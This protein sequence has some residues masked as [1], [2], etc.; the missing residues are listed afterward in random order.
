MRSRA[1]DGERSYMGLYTLANP[2]VV[3]LLRR[4]PQYVAAPAVRLQEALAG[5]L[6]LLGSAPDGDVLSRVTEWL[7]DLDEHGRS[8]HY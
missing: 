5:E 3:W 6:E 4:E 8:V 2:W 7:D 1:A